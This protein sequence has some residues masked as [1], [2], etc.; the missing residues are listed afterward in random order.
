MRELGVAG[1]IGTVIALGVG[2]TALAYVA[3][4]SLA[5]RVGGTRASVTVYFAPP[6][7]LLLG[8]L[9]RD[10]TVALLSALGVLVVLGGAWLAGRADSRSRQRSA[11]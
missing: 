8:V 3:A 11:L 2:G 4:T 5:G 7:A 10:E 6:V 1:A 9:V